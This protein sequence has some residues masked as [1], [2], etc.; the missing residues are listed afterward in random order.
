MEADLLRYY[1]VD[2]RDFYRRRG[3]SAG[4]TLRRLSVLVGGLPTD[5][6]LSRL[7]GTGFS[8]TEVLL[9]EVGHAGPP[10]FRHPM[11]EAERAKVTSRAQL[12][13]DRA[14]YYKAQGARQAAESESDEPAEEGT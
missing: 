8:L 6:T 1:A 10:S 4:L 2:F 11:H 5:S 12:I 9:M 7:Q 3:G 14:A 13:R